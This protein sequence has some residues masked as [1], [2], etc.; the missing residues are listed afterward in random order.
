MLAIFFSILREITLKEAHT[1]LYDVSKQG[2]SIFGGNK[3]SLEVH[4]RRNDTNGTKVAAILER[5]F[6]ATE[7]ELLLCEQWLIKLVV[8][9]KCTEIEIK[10]VAELAHFDFLKRIRPLTAHW[11]KI[12]G[13]S[14]P[15]KLLTAG[16]FEAACAAAG[17]NV[18]QWRNA[19]LKKIKK[20]RL[21]ESSSKEQPRKKQKQQQLSSSSS[22]SFEC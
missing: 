17:S 5:V 3:F 15:D 20:S 22:S 19:E 21:P 2:R 8:D 6:K 14:I 18:A 10:K 1:K 9:S 16:K 13:L 12:L 4:S 11:M 7:A